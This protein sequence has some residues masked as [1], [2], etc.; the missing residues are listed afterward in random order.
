M[1]HPP[2]GHEKKLQ[3]P[4]LNKKYIHSFMEIPNNKFAMTNKFQHTAQAAVLRMTEI[5]NP[6]R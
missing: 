4:N 3:P 2:G 6:M 5:Q 1:I